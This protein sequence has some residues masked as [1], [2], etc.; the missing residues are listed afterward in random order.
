MQRLVLYN[1]VLTM[2]YQLCNVL[3]LEHQ[4]R[5]QGQDIVC[6]ILGGFYMYIAN[7]TFT[8][9]AVIITYLLYLVL[10][11]FTTGSLSQSKWSNWF[12][13][14]LCIAVAFLLPL[15]FLWTPFLHNGFGLGGFYCWIKDVEIDC[16]RNY[17]ALIIMYSVSEVT[18][19][20]ML[21]ASCV[22]FAIYYRMHTKV[23]KQYV[24]SL[25]RKTCCLVSFHGVGFAVVTVAFGLVFYLLVKNVVVLN[26]SLLFSEAIIFPFFYEFALI[27]LFFVSVRTSNSHPNLPGKRSPRVRFDTAALSKNLRTRPSKPSFVPTN[28]PS[29]T[30]SLTVPYT[31][32]FTEIT[33]SI[34]GEGDED[35]VPLVSNNGNCSNYEATSNS[36]EQS[37]L[38]PV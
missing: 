1:A 22:V 13:E 38:N 2:L 5:Y 4:F 21:V 12:V 30:R 34:N 32:A 8:F 11:L 9:A 6:A 7:V 33:A 25:I 29:N 3:Q 20:E 10:K 36:S 31:G 24:N 14:S 17:E 37:Y 19:V 16:G 26:Q 28:Q 35:K 23:Q 18:S 27:V 15:T